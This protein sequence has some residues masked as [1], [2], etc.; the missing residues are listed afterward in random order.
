MM[1]WTNEIE[2]CFTIK[3]LAWNKNVLAR[4]TS[5]RELRRLKN[6]D[7]ICASKRCVQVRV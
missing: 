1:D 3:R 2:F 6:S 7:M 4:S 5:P